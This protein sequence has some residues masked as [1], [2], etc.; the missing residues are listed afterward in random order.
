LNNGQGLADIS[1]DGAP[2]EFET[3]WE[4]A[5]N[6]YV[7]PTDFNLFDEQPTPYIGARW[8]DPAGSKEA[9]PIDYV[10]WYEAYAFCIWDGDFLPSEAEWE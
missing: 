5:W 4:T 1:N 9:L 2:D 3:G 6:Q 7:T 8:T 10:S